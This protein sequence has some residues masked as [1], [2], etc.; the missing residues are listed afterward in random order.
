MLAVLYYT[1][2]YYIV[3]YYIYYTILCY[4]I[5]HCIILLKVNAIV[6]ALIFE[7][8]VVIAV[9]D[10]VGGVAAALVAA[11]VTRWQQ[12]RHCLMW[13]RGRCP[14]VDSVAK[15]KMPTCC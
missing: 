12:G 10:G 7:M 14:R 4:S 11:R 5:L 3:L 8:A 9:V 15:G 2:L 1:I 6:F 13:L